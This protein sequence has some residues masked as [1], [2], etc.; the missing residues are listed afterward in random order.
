LAWEHD[1]SVKLADVN[2]GTLGVFFQRCE[3][4]GFDGLGFRARLENTPMGRQVVRIL[5]AGRYG[6]SMG[7]EDPGPNWTG[8]GTDLKTSTDVFE[9]SL[10]K[11]PAFGPAA[12][13]QLNWLVPEKSTW[14]ILFGSD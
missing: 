1:E 13:V 8:G 12:W 3:V 11:A 2:S 5:A 14:P 7:F 9:L 10:V 6:V 4:A